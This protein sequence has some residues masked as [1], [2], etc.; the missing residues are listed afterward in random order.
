M[1]CQKRVCSAQR[2]TTVTTTFT[3]L[4]VRRQWSPCGLV[5]QSASAVIIT[6]THAYDVLERPLLHSS[7]TICP[8]LLTLRASCRT[9]TGKIQGRGHRIREGMLPFVTSS[10]IPPNVV[11]CPGYTADG[12]TDRGVFATWAGAQRHI[13]TTFTETGPSIV[14]RTRTMIRI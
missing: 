11:A 14:Q 8:T 6:V 5:L 4:L 3:T 10:S 7:L 2:N 12:P 13:M 9:D 1:K